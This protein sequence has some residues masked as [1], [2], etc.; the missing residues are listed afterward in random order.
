M[1]KSGSN[2]KAALKRAKKLG[3]TIAIGK[4][5]ELKISHASR[6]DRMFIVASHRKDCPRVLTTMLQQLERGRR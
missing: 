2:L 1:A 6:P 5:G 3:C 4:G